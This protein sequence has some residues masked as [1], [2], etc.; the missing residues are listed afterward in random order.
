MMQYRKTSK[1]KDTK[2]AMRPALHLFRQ[3]HMTWTNWYAHIHTTTPHPIN[4]SLYPKRYEKH[5]RI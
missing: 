4:I 5:A 2:A 3:N 1:S